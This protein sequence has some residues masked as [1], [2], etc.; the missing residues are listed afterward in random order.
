M[1]K[2]TRFT[3]TEGLAALGI[4]ESLVITLID[5]KV[6]TERDARDL[7]T[8]V[9]TTHRAA[10]AKSPTPEKHLEVVEIIARVLVGK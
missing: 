8:D 6:I 2:P 9:A 5:L 1:T 3:D 7:L 4:C 10:V